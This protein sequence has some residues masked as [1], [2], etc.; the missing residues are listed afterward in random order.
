MTEIL[1]LFISAPISTLLIIGGI[2]MMILSVASSIGS[3]FQV[4]RT[5]QRWSGMMGV[6][7]VVAGIAMM[8]F[9]PSP[10]PNAMPAGQAGETSVAS[11]EGVQVKAEIAAQEPPTA[12]PNIVP[13][14]PT[15]TS[16]VVVPP[17]DTAQSVPPTETAQS[18]PPTDTAQPI[19]PTQAPEAVQ[20]P[21]GQDFT[22]RMKMDKGNTLAIINLS[23]QPFPLWLLDIRGPNGEITGDMWGLAE[24]EP[25]MCALAWKRPGS[26]KEPKVKECK[27]QVSMA[28]SPSMPWEDEI[29]VY[30]S[31]QEIGVCSQGACEFS[32]TIQ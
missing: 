2:G 13:A 12:A 23:K 6:V 3:K 31:G 11:S 17:T 30:F 28:F 18:I 1:T 10:T 26:Q 9:N 15:A 5:R 27:A 29:K 16:V 7:L 24:L 25:E 20:L 22:I 8:I 21:A 32:I 4:D 19:P 14:E